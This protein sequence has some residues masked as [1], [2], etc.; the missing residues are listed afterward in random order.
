MPD[1]PYA[2]PYLP[3]TGLMGTGYTLPSYAPM[4]GNVPQETGS[5]SSL[6]PGILAGAGSLFGLVNGI[7]QILKSKRMNPVRPQYEIP[8]ETKQMLGLRENLLNAEM[9][10]EQQARQDIATTQAN[11]MSNVARGA[12]DQG[13]YLGLLG[14]LQGQANKSY[15]NLATEQAQNY[16]AN[17]A[18]LERAQQVMAA[19]KD[20]QWELNK[21]DPYLMQLQRKY[22]LQN[23]GNQNI[24]SGISGLSSLAGASGSSGGGMS[25]LMS[26]LPMLA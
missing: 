23:A 18:G 10:G 15:N 11:A 8:D 14:A 12:S 13:Q 20:K 1:N 9:P 24:E 4:A 19:A 6:N 2:L 26:L 25:S 21:Y 16:N 17:V 22:Q 7:G 3:N 5:S